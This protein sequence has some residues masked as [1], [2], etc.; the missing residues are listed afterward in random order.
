MPAMGEIDKT[1][2]LICWFALQFNAELSVLLVEK[3]L[4][5][6]YIIK[7]TLIELL[8]FMFKKKLNEPSELMKQILF[9]KNLLLLRK[10]LTKVLL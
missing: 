7:E 3:N 5:L 2:L 6:E 8:A 1:L 4:A 10:L 9:K